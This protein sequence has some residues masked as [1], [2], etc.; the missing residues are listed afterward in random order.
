VDGIPTTV[1]TRRYADAVGY[2]CD[3]HA[4]QARKGTRV[5]YAAHLMGVSSL[6]LEAGAD[7]DLAIA[8]LLH[9]A[10]E[11]HGGEARL[12]DIEEQFGARVARIVRDCSD[13]L[14]PDGVEKDDWETRKH[15]HLARLAEA[16]DETLIVWMADK[17][18]NG[19][20]I[21]TDVEAQGADVLGR[22]NAPPD[23]ILWYYE[24]NLALASARHVPDALLVPLRDAVARLRTLLAIG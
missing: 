10:A 21:I 15:E 2:A 4:A 20:A 9:D 5:P 14:V 18:H 13:S 16:S 22:F 11:D 6:V 23:R 1:L 8:A 19:R 3:V 17:V 12:A 7:E 24:A